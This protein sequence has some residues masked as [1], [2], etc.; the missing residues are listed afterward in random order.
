M[1]FLLFCFFQGGDPFRV[2]IIPNLPAQVTCLC[3]KFGMSDTVLGIVKLDR[4][5]LG[6]LFGD[7]IPG[8]SI[9]LFIVMSII[10]NYWMRL[11]MI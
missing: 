3:A 5:R 6:Y 4:S 11:S 1:Y 8:L 2:N 9:F 7:T 10:S